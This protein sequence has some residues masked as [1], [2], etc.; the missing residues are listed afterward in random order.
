MILYPLLSDEPQRSHPGTKA[1][2]PAFTYTK[3]YGGKE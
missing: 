2:P 3:A 1:L